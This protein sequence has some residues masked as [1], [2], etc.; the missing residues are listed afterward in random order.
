[1]ELNRFTETELAALRHP[2]RRVA[3]LAGVPFEHGHP[4]Q[5]FFMLIW[6]PDGGVQVVDKVRW[7]EVCPTDQTCEE[8]LKRP[9]LT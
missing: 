9:L 2:S 6:A 3:V 7:Y 8:T 4:E 5:G 1:M